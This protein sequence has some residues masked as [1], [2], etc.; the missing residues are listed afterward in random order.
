MPEISDSNAEQPPV[1]VACPPVPP[2]TNRM[3]YLQESSSS[4]DFTASLLTA[5]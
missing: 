5:H 2:R 4:G 1:R 3:A